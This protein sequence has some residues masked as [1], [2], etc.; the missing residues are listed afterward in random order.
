MVNVNIFKKVFNRILFSF[1]R[2]WN[3]GLGQSY[4]LFEK[5]TKRDLNPGFYP[6][7]SCPRVEMITESGK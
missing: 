2:K 6:G 7:T 3:Y 1:N 4:L 5:T